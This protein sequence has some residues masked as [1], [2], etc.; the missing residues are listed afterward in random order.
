DHNL[1]V[2]DPPN[3]WYVRWENGL[4]VCFSRVLTSASEDTVWTLP[5]AFIDSS[6]VFCS[7]IGA[8]FAD[9]ALAI[10]FEGRTTSSLTLRVFRVSTGARISGSAF[11]I[12]IG[13]WK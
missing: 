5:A 4:Q 2:A 13:R 7:A 6:W 10:T 1:D 8:T 3:G 12:A 9:G 11:I